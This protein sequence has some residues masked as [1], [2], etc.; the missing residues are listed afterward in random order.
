MSAVQHGLLLLNIRSVTLV[1]LDSLW[2]N[3]KI[4]AQK[5]DT[6]GKDLN[7][8]AHFCIILSCF[9]VQVDEV[10]ICEFI[11]CSRKREMNNKAEG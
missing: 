6:L 5:M 3:Y 10:V 11:P 2:S 4:R 8:S 1:Q 7:I 9:Q